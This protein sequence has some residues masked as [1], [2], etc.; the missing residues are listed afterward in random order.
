MGMLSVIKAAPKTFLKAGGKALFALKK[1]KPE[2]LVG[3][4]IVIATG[5]FIMAICNARKLDAAMAE[6]QARV[7]AI[8]AKRKD[9]PD[10]DKKSLKEWEKEL[11]KAKAEAVWKVFCLIGVPALVFA[12]GIAMTIGGHVILFRRFGELSVSFAALQNRFERYRR[13][14]IE[15]HGAECD[16]KYI[17]GIT[18]NAETTATIT[19]NNGKEKQVKCLVPEVDKDAS[20]GM[21]TFI[22]SEEFSRKWNRDPIMNISFLKQQENYWNAYL[23]T[24]RVVILKNVLDD[25]GIELDPDDPANDYTMIAGWRPNG[26]GDRHV[27]FGLMSAVNKPT[28]D[29][30]ENY[31][32]LNFNCDGNLYHSNRYDRDGRKI[33]AKAKVKGA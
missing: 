22:F 23:G 24:G 6:T 14:N 9:I 2:I 26:D 16:K 33:V 28:L 10:D 20:C 29:L 4:G 8:E 13:M 15:E 27:D 18:G 1:A 17:Y 30:R 21:Y 3:G 7:E 31:I 11:N 25:L 19:D 12:G 32:V 5:A